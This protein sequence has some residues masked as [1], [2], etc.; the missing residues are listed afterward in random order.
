MF[1]LGGAW[2][3][4]ST[5]ER[6]LP[7]LLPTATTL[8]LR[9]PIAQRNC[10][11]IRDPAR[12]DELWN[13]VSEPLP[14]GGMV[15]PGPAAVS[16]WFTSRQAFLEEIA[17]RFKGR[18]TLVVARARLDKDPELQ[19]VLAVLMVERRGGSMKDEAGLKGR[20][21]PL[22]LE[23]NAAR[24]WNRGEASVAAVYDA[25]G[26]EVFLCDDSTWLWADEPS[27]RSG[28][29]WR[30]FNRLARTLREE[31]R[32]REERAAGLARA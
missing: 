22:F 18:E 1:E 10:P 7:F 17:A 30:L 4:E 20:D 16:P 28:I 32:A 25:F 11:S 19:R 15:Q 26:E 24:P 8:Q 27:P 14:G 21:L 12:L 23:E 2:A 5:S 6:L 29:H 3:L 9:G 13:R 31:A